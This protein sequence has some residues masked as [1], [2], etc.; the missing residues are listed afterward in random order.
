M[1]CS[2]CSTEIPPAFV[3]CYERNKCPICDGAIMDE[4]TIG[5]MTG[6]ADAMSKMENDP[7]GLAG[8]LLSN[9]RMEKVGAGEPTGFHRLKPEKK[10]PEKQQQTQAEAPKGP[11][12]GLTDFYKRATQQENAKPKPKSK[13][14]EI[15]AKC[16]NS[17]GFPA[18][19]INEL[20]GGDISEAEDEL[21]SMP[22]EDTAAVME[23]LVNNARAKSSGLKGDML[24][25]AEIA[26]TLYKQQETSAAIANG[27]KAMSRSG[28]P[29][30][31]SR[32]G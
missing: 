25:E 9:Y 3:A 2:N 11:V 14:E 13:K 16:D 20:T 29:A 23:A 21:S 28:K 4:N 26:K 10:T 18:S 8:W 27:E 31:F 1:K 6:L 17:G 7:Q 15:L 30:G 24:V 19:V 5:L 22:S 12:D 32:A